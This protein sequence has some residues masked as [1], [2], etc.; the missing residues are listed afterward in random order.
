MD[1][2]VSWRII[3]LRKRRTEAVCAR[4]PLGGS[5]SE[6]RDNSVSNVDVY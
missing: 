5:V 4:D 2:S 3:A 1:D 6:P